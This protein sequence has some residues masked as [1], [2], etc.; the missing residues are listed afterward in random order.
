MRMEMYNQNSKTSGG[1]SGLGATMNVQINSFCLDQVKK[2][3]ILSTFFF[4]YY[5]TNRSVFNC[6]S[7]HLH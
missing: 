2:S 7:L 1:G 4:S 6:S 3:H 5:N